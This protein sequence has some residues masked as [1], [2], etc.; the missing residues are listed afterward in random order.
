LAA[1]GVLDG[2]G[3]EAVDQAA[4]D[5]VE[6]AFNAALADELPGSETAFTDVYGDDRGVPR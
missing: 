1:A 5:A 4:R 6:A 3:A 2:A